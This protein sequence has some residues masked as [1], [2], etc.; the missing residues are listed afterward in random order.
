MQVEFFPLTITRVEPLTKD[1]IAVTFQCRAEDKA[2]FQYVHGQHLTLRLDIDG[3]E[4]RRSYSLCGDPA[5]QELT[6]GIKRIENGVFSNYAIE[7]FKP[8]MVIEAMPPQGHFYSEL[9]PDA[10]KHYLLIAAGSGITPNL[11]HLQAIL[12]TEAKSRVTLIY[13]NQSTPSMMFR[14]KLSFLKNR[15]LDRLH[16][17]N[18]FS[19]EDQESPLLNGRVSMQRLEDMHKANLLDLDSVD[20]V[21]LCGPQALILSLAEGF[22]T[23]GLDDDKVHYELFFAGS[24]DAKADARAA[25]RAA[26]YHDQLASVALKVGG[27]TTR[28]ELAKDGATILDAAMDAGADVPYSC[29]GGVCATCKAK[30]VKGEVEMDLN[31]SL[32]A[33]EVAEGMVLTCQAHPISDQV[34][35]DFDVAN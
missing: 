29:K 4:I 35:V 8:G 12:Q 20:E 24:G 33:E 21:F 14:E 5:A 30:V 13:Q 32:T 17:I 6:V 18:Q 2:R 22:K 23:R 16:W 15:Y 26:K 10:A 25:E 19:R 34:E 3:E 1:A 9:D 27:R 28:F 31:H 7:H 11:S